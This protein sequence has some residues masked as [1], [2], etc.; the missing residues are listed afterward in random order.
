MSGATSERFFT[1]KSA[2]LAGLVAATAA[3]L[4][5]LAGA[6]PAEARFDDDPPEEEGGGSATPGGPPPFVMP[7][8]GFDWKAPARQG[9]W[10]SAW[11]ERGYV[12]TWPSETYDP[13]YV[14]PSSWDLYF[15]GCQTEADYRYDID[16]DNNPKTENRY[17]WSWNGK[18]REFSTECY[19]SLDFPAQGIYSVELTV[20]R[21]DGTQSTWVHP[22]Q[23]KD[24]V[25]VVLGDSSAS[26][27]GAPD[28]PAGQFEGPSANADW[29]D[30]RCHRSKYAGGAQA[31]RILEEADPH[32]SVTFLSFACSGATL[33]TMLYAGSLPNDPYV[34]TNYAER[35]TGITGPYVGIEPPVDQSGNYEPKLPGQTEQMYMALSDNGY[36][37]PRKVDAL[38]VAGGIND[39]RFSSLAAVCLFNPFCYGTPV[40]GIPPVLLDL[41]FSSDVSRVGPGWNLLADQLEEFGIQA[42]RKLALEYPPFFEDDDGSQCLL[43]FDDI[44]GPLFGWTAD[45]IAWADA[46]WAPELNNAVKAA[47]QA[48]GFTYVSG[49]A[50]GFDRHGMCADDRFINTAQDSAVKQGDSEGDSGFFAGLSSTGTA[51][52]NADGYAVY[53]DRIVDHFDQLIDNEA[54]VGVA[55]KIWAGNLAFLPTWFNVLDNDYDPDP[56]DQLQ[57][58]IDTYPTHGKVELAKNGS[59]SYRADNGYVGTDSFRYEVTDGVFSRF[60]TVTIIVEPVVIEK[61]KVEIGSDSTI[62][63]ML[64]DFTLT[65]PYLVE[66]DNP[67]ALDRGEIRVVPN[68]DAIYFNAPPKP[69]RR[70]LRMPYTVYSLTTDRTS[71]DYGRSVRGIL[72]LRMVRRLR[73]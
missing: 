8:N 35:G 36:R 68:D 53:A 27:E 28:K 55:D 51:H 18:T 62:D 33:N 72:K 4:Q 1:L 58:L 20:K 69:R 64:G 34:I 19:T 38:I 66:F 63:G 37:T 48:N 57:V 9:R 43:L 32:T 24:Y 29:V 10:V 14:N 39:A 54:P 21:P 46:Y 73:L 5:L 65:P 17:R 42:D 2:R 60:V 15:Q 71:P 56:E 49:I 13:E 47:A 25:V 31:A 40:G 44:L 30:D 7:Q 16:P 59:G 11:A 6:V 41:Q 70:N 52:P 23:V 50:S 67:L 26:G 45:E 61:A 22:V 3:A 12:R